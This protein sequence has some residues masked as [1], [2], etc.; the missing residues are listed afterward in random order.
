MVSWDGKAIHAS[1]RGFC[2][3]IRQEDENRPRIRYIH[4]SNYRRGKHWEWSNISLDPE[5]VR[6]QHLAQN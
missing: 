1:R 6:T 5:D 4:R 2:R 3:K